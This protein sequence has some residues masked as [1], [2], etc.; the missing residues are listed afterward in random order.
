MA[1][2]ADRTIPETES[3]GLPRQLRLR[4]LVLTQ[5]L[6][7]V[8]SAWVG[9]AAGLGRGQAVTWIVA[10]ALFYLPMSASVICLNRLMPL[11]GG[12]YIWARAAFG[13]RGGFLTAWNLWVYGI[14][15][16]ASILYAIPTELSYLIGPS[17][18]WIPENHA[19]SLTLVA[20]LLVALAAAAMRGLDLG[21]WI[22]NVGG[23]AI[24][25]AFAALI[26]LP[27]WPVTHHFP[28][29]YDPLP[30]HLP[31]RTM[32]SLAIF[33][34]MI[35]GALSGIEYIAI[36]AGE[37]RSPTRDIGRSVW[38]ASPVICGMFILGTDSVLTFAH[39]GHIDFIAP[40]PQ[41]LRLALGSSGLGNVLAIALIAL[42][43][44]RLLGA[45]SYIFTGVTRL[46]M[47]AG[48]DH[49]IPTWFTRLHPRH[50]T[51]TNSILATCT[52]I[53]LLLLLASVGVHA[54]EA[55]QVLTNAAVT[56]YQLAYIAM[57]SIPLLGTATL[58]RQ[59]P[60]WLRLT[61]FTGLCATL[62]SFLI[63]AYPFVS[64]VNAPAYAAKILG[65]TLTSNL[66]A[67]TFF[68]LRRRSIR[69]SL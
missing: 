44:L 11:E 10:M 17:A 41:T 5:I 45:A 21:K 42:L 18:A 16:T 55:F 7:V 47:T 3:H 64:V 30:I 68:H 19:V 26:L 13:D 51:P 58:R 57:F 22:H 61:S 66:I 14:V 36:F 29:R 67:L 33:G 38:I 43:Q 34:Q 4:D 28:V 25:T 9:V 27:L 56:H 54:Q 1:S 59:L 62:F 23:I 50:H 37:S 15:V 48:W 46:P 31:P 53:L 35:V 40:I 12:L 69:P 49:L 65:T 24:L 60:R 8:G 6:C 20:T 63:S 52:L 32:V 39:P 2:T